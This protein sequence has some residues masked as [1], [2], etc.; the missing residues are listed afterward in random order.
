MA[1]CQKHYH[2]VPVE[3][4]RPLAAATMA[5]FAVFVA[6][7]TGIFSV[8]PGGGIVAGIVWIAAVFDLCRYLH[9]GKLICHD[10]QVCVI[11][12][13]GELIPVGADKS[14]PDTM[15]DDFT[16]NIILS[17]HSS[18]ET[19]SEMV[20]TDPYQGKYIERQ[21]GPDSLGLGWEGESIAFSGLAPHETEVLHCEVKGCRVHDVCT[22]LKVMSFPTAAVAVVCSLPIIGWAACLI[23]LAIVVA[24]TLIVGGIVWAATHNGDLYDVLDPTSGFPGEANP[25]TGLG[26]DIVLVRGDWVYDAGHGG[27][28]EIHPVRY[29]Q[30]LDNVPAQFHGATR[31]DAALVDLFN[32]EVLDPWC[33]EVSRTED[34]SVVDGQGRPENSWQIHPSIDGCREPVIVE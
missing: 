12:R 13:V 30:R 14:F 29:V 28:N 3:D 34:P 23:A 19:A 33:F 1:D 32:S 22:V 24:I 7:L 27:W 26:G 25:V 20:A 6:V 8:P 11:G 31:A 10:L 16:F 9:G 17:P 4:Y 5:L 21:P 18:D 15:D 2:C